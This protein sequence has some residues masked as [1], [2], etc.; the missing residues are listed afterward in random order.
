MP[1][2]PVATGV[3]RF[4]IDERNTH[5]CLMRICRQGKKYQEFFSDSVYGGKRKA[6]AAAIARYE[7]LAASL[8]SRGSTKDKLTDRNQ[9]GRVGVYIAV[10]RDARGQ[11]YEAYCAGWTDDK[12]V[13]RKINFA[14]NKYGEKMAWELACFA[15]EKQ[16]HDRNKVL[17]LYQRQKNFKAPRRKK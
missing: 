6:L 12:G 2:K 17:D 9:T 10:S 1:T 11:E 7:E 13:R 3:T 4:D 15:R 5:G 8:P 14:I 16:V